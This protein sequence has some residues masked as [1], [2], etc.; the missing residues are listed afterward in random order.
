VYAFVNADSATNNTD[1]NRNT[2]VNVSGDTV[3]G[4][5]EII[6]E[7]TGHTLK[8]A[9]PTTHLALNGGNDRLDGS[10]I[11]LYGTNN[12]NSAYDGRMLIFSDDIYIGE[13]YN[14]ITGYGPWL[15][16]YDVNNQQI[17]FGGTTANTDK[18]LTVK[19]EAFLE[20]NLTVSGDISAKGDI[21]LSKSSLIFSDGDNRD[22]EVWT[23]IDSINSKD[24][25]TSVTNTSGSWD[26]VYSYTQSDSATNNTTYNLTHFVNTSGDE[27]TGDLT[28][29]GTVSATNAIF[30][31]LTALSTVINVVDIKARELSGYRSDFVW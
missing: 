25:Y 9:D 11:E 2:F 1:Y 26:S 24:T 31:Y 22:D 12:I 21:Y 28:V 15:V 18:L 4:D 10:A 27:M 23:S 8:T 17:V 29:E 20:D 5:L 3:T 19:G 7:I 16:R 6:G 13:I 14:D 30:T